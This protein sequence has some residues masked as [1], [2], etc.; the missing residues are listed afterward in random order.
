M[1]ALNFTLALT[2]FCVLGEGK[3]SAKEKRDAAVAQRVCAVRGKKR[4][5][6]L[7]TK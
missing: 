3:V 6:A 7:R 4:M 5:S 2:V 1:V